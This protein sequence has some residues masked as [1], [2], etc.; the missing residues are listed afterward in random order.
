LYN[1]DFLHFRRNTD[2]YG[3]S[4]FEDSNGT[5]LERAIETLISAEGIGKKFGSQWVIRDLSFE[6]KFGDC[7]IVNGRNGAGKSTLIR[8]LAG[9]ERPT[10]GTVRHTL[11]YQTE[12]G[13]SALDQA[14]FPNLTVR[15]HLELASEMRGIQSDIDDLIQFVELV[16]HRDHQSVQLSSGLRSRL[17]LALAIQ[18]NPKFLI[19]DEPSVALDEAGRDLVERV[20]KAQRERGA[21]VI[22][23]NDPEERRLGSHLLELT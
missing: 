2:G 15:E 8:V 4:L 13:F 20:V 14:V 6:V 16:D 9:L 19:L 21:A 7:L 3:H 17:K 18:S 1:F 22:A 5:F 23:S 10:T 11:D 12:I